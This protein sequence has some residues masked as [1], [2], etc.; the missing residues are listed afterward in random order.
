M[1]TTISIIGSTGSIGR[2]TLE[3]IQK[4]PREFKV[5]AL[6]CYENI[7][8]L[9]EQIVR[10]QPAFVA[11]YKTAAATAL[12]QK[13]A[14]SSLQKFPKILSGPAGWVK[15]ATLQQ[16]DKTIF[17][18]NG[19]TALSTLLEAIK[20]RKQIALAS[21]ELLVAAG[22]LIMD[23]AKKYKVTIVP[24]DSEHSAIFQCLQGEDPR[25]VE[26]IVLTCSGGPFFGKSKNELAKVSVKAALNHPTW[27]MGAKIS[28]DCATLMNK[29]FEVIEAKYLFG[30]R[31]D[32]IEIIIHPESIVHSLVY[33]KD[34][35][36]KM[37]AAL[38]D[39]RVPIT[40]ALAY[41]QRITSDWP[42]IDLKKVPKLTFLPPDFET[43]RA[44]K[45]AYKTAKMG[46]N[47]PA[48][49][50]RANHL[51]VQKFL[52]GKI[53]F[54]QIYEYTERT[55]KNAVFIKKPTLNYLQ[56]LAV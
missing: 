19:L 49:L 4:H 50:T 40:Y 11:V 12:K 45:L 29:G 18:S 8:L 31:E 52:D 27:N 35:N 26:K 2:Q 30:L 25:T 13:L 5:V 3:V 53:T 55:V 7:D 1:H 48:I 37:Q 56:K 44:P 32:Q 34:G 17:S 54:P 9:A 16:A 28:V 39:M 41:P 10:F 46:G 33:F 14:V 22:E 21:K 24:I 20:A 51:N 36:V 47:L 23:L 38:P 43:F 6:A 42:R 15:L